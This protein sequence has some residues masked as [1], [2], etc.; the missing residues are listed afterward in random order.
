MKRS[1]PVQKKV[2]PHTAGLNHMLYEPRQDSAQTP[3]IRALRLL[4]HYINV[5]G[6]HTY[7]LPRKE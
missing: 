4:D 3:L 2:S 7:P 1:T 6:H 5:S